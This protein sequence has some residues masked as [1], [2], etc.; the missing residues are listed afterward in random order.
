MFIR[1]TARDAVGPKKW[2]RDL[3]LNDL[4]WDNIFVRSMNICKD[5]KL[6]EF[7][8]KLIHRM[9]ATNKELY[10]Y[11]IEP[12]DNCYYC[13]NPDSIIH[14]FVECHFSNTFCN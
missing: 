9:V 8:Y 7:C 11:G 6:M 1:K 14:T 3:E 4:N 5:H 2:E 12:N 13:G 10:I